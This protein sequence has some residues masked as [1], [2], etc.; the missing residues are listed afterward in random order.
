MYTKT[1]LGKVSDD[2]V[3]G[4]VELPEEWRSEVNWSKHRCV[5]V[6]VYP[7]QQKV[8]SCTF[9]RVSETTLIFYLMFKF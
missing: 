7:T 9:L 5:K 8:T 6:E 1:E 3:L 2:N 4:H